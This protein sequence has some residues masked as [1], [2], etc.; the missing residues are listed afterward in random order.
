MLPFGQR[1][2]VLLRLGR[3][4]NLLPEAT[5]LSPI[6]VSRNSW[7][8]PLVFCVDYLAG[9]I[10]S[11]PPLRQDSESLPFV[12]YNTYAWLTADNRVLG[13]NAVVLDHH[14]D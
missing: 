4:R 5:F 2:G 11:V 8:R 6:A 12:R 10:H 14:I 9:F 13:D 7:L 3:W 1:E